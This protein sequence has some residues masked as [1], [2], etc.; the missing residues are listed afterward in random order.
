VGVISNLSPFEG[1]RWRRRIVGVLAVRLVCGA[2]DELVAKRAVLGGLDSTRQSGGRGVR[3]ACPL[4][5]VGMRCV[6][7][8]VIV[9]LAGS[10]DGL[11][12]GKSGSRPIGEPDSDSPVDLD[13]R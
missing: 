6:Q 10:K 11:E 5:Q 2:A 9:E 7:R 12:H 1:Q 13:N 8:A 3:L 4:Q